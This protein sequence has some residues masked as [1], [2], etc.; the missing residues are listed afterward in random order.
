MKAE[1]MNREDYP[2]Y[3]NQ[4]AQCASK[5]AYEAVTS[6]AL[7]E[8]ILYWNIAEAVLT[9]LFREVIGIVNDIAIKQ[10]NSENETQGIQVQV[11]ELKFP[12][13][14]VKSYLNMVVNESLKEVDDETSRR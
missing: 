5:A 9:P 1:K 12:N 11:K 2:Q 10:V 4:V 13:E 6:K 8:G 3:V 7:P 14:R